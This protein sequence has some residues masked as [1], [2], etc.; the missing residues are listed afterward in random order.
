MGYGAYLQDLLR[1]LGVY[2]FSASGFSGAE[3]L[4]LGEALDELADYAAEKQKES[5]VMTAEGEGLDTMAALFPWLVTAAGSAEKRN[6]LAGFLQVGEDSFTKDCLQRCL[7]ACGTACMLRETGEH[8]VV[9]VRFPAFSGV[10]DEFE[11]KKK[12]IESILPCH[13]E[14]RYAFNWCVFGDL[15]GKMT[16]G[17]AADLTFAELSLWGLE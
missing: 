11:A 8:S 6:A 4:A 12:I 3:L 7:S 13:L 2:D 1:P 9:E 10:P 16:W 15:A 14:V 17:Q 5:L